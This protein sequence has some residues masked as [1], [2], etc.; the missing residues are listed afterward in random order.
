MDDDKVIESLFGG[1]MIKASATPDSTVEVNLISP[2]AEE[3]VDA[4]SDLFLKWKD[5]RNLNVEGPCAIHDDKWWKALQWLALADS[6]LKDMFVGRD[7]SPRSIRI[8]HR[9]R[10]TIVAGQRKL[11]PDA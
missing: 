6:K 8:Y 4:A 9:Y 2:S 10:L 5:F 11:R 1:G 7:R 3:V